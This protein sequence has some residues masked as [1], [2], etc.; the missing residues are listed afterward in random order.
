MVS[1]LFVDDEPNV[2]A[3]FERHFRKRYAVATAPGGAEGLAALAAG[4]PFAV[5]VSDMRMPGMDGVEFL[6]RA[7]AAHPDLVRVLLTGYADVSQ[8][9]GAVNQGGIFR[10]LTKP[11]SLADLTAAIDAAADQYRLVT[12]ERELLDRTLKG[13]VQV[14]GEVL[15]LAAPEEF[16][17]AVRVQRLARELGGGAGGWAAEVA[18]V[19]SQ[20]GSIVVPAGVLRAAARGA[21][22]SPADQR[23]LDDIP[24]AAAA[25]LRHIPRLEPVTE[26]LGHIAT[27]FAPA[28]G[29]APLRAGKDIPPGA[30][31]LAV[32]FDFDTLVE[33]GAPKPQALKLLRAR[34]G[35]Y[36]PDVLDALEA[37]L[38]REAEPDAREVPVG[39]LADG[40]LLAEDLYSDA[41]V[42]LLRR[43]HPVTAPARRRLEVMA[44]RGQ[45]PLHIRVLVPR[46]AG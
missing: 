4:G 28:A 44:A 25:L 29:T 10:F 33:R 19:L 14:L 41:G 37:G 2:L 18:A 20:L 24:A 43:G 13:S 22:L 5:V 7:R 21:A 26:V 3:G 35:R 23:Q 11:C 46:P 17:R 16:G 42:L 34:A 6:T 31:V 45:A 15:A 38:R 39:E 32:A 27:P 30:R 36:D 40:M 8:A 1:V 12:G 9:I